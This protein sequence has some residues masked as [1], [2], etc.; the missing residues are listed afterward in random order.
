MFFHFL[1]VL[2]NNAYI[3]L[4]IEQNTELSLSVS[5][6]FIGNNYFPKH[7]LRQFQENRSITK[8]FP[9]YYLLIVNVQSNFTH[10]I[11]NVSQNCD[12]VQCKK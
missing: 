3:L 8:S 5:L 4:K 9:N 6:D 10:E 11:Q 1:Y 7:V 2:L 12:Y